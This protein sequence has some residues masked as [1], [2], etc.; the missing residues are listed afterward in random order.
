[1]TELEERL[2]RYK[3]PSSRHERQKQD[4][5]EYLVKEAVRDWHG[6]SGISFRF[7][8]KGSYANNTNVR[9]D[10][11]VDIAVIHQGFH[12]YNDSALRDADKPVRT[13]ITIPH[14]SGTAFRQEL[15]K[16]LCDSFTAS[17]CDTTGNTAISIVENSSRVSADAVPSYE[18]RQYYYN[19]Y[20]RV[21]YHLGT[22][23]CRKDGSWV[24]NYPEQQYTNGVAKNKRTGGRYK[25]AARILKRIENDM[26]AAG[27]IAKLPSYFMECM[28]YCV[29]DDKYGHGGLTPLTADLKAVLYFLWA[30]S[31]SGGAA[32][33]WYEPNGIKK[34]FGDGQKWSVQDVRN[35]SY[36]AWNFLGL[37]DA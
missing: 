34:L 24:V 36:K 15:E 27:E 31:D 14:L 1:M 12:Y 17:D 10:S 11:D 18:H 3:E 37:E 30:N 28:A 29:P 13:P 8:P 7:L 9:L 21:A 2:G 19:E 26:A 33:S 6:F 4:R 25:F 5:A 35:F 23:T 22:T 16:A 32:A 20:G